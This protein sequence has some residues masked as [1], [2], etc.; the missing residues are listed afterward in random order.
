[1]KIQE[2]PEEDEEITIHKNTQKLVEKSVQRKILIEEEETFL[3][4]PS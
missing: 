2:E 1:V 4:Q 3:S